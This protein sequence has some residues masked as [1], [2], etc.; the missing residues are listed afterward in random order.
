MGVYDRSK[1]ELIASVMRELGLKRALVVASLDGLDEISIAAP[2]QVTELKNG[3]IFTYQLS[4]Q[5][6]GLDEAP[7]DAVVGGDAAENAAMIRSIF[8]GELGARRDIVLANTGAAFYVTG[9]TPTIAEGV[10]HAADIIDSGKAK[11]K[12]VQLIEC[13]GAMKDVS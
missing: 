10:K 11:E 1:T 2:T 13:T 6:I 9:I 4:P 3:D 7:L 12:L 8:D 5:E